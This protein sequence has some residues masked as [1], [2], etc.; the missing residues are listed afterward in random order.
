MEK[1]TFL[2]AQVKPRRHDPPTRKAVWDGRIAFVPID[3]YTQ[4]QK[5]SVATLKAWI[6]WENQNVDTEDPYLKLMEQPGC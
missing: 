4:A 6:K 2:S 5:I 1:M 3:E